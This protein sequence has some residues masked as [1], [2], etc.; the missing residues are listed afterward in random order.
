MEHRSSLLFISI[1]T[2]G[3]RKVAVGINRLRDIQRNTRTADEPRATIPPRIRNKT[4]LAMCSRANRRGF[5][6]IRNCSISISTTASARRISDP[7]R[8]M[9]TEVRFLNRAQV[10]RLLATMVTMLITK[11]RPSRR[12]GI[13]VTETL[14]TSSLRPEISILMM[15][16]MV[17]I[18]ERNKMEPR[19]YTPLIQAKRI[20][21]IS[22]GTSRII[23]LAAECP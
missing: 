15:L 19:K 22:L 6:V 14:I 3:T 17:G 2:T 4:A 12:E 9:I 13:S 23:T 5:N 21:R 11:I 8:R 20:S 10:T 1:F 18:I 7:L 16:L